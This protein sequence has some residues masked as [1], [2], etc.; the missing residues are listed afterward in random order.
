MKQTMEWDGG[1]ENRKKSRKTNEK[2]VC[3]CCWVEEGRCEKID[4]KNFPK[5]VQNLVETLLGFF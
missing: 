5:V 1:G 3:C 2:C 4:W